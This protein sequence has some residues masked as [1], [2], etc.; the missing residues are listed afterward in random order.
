MHPTDEDLSAGTPGS[1]RTVFPIARGGMLRARSRETHP[2]WQPSGQ[3][4]IFA[5]GD[6]SPTTDPYS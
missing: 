5:R 3:T 1:H 4:F 6:Y 2:L